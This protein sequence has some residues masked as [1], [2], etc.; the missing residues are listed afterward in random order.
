MRDDDRVKIHGDE[1]FLEAIVGAV[2]DRPFFLD[3]TAVK[4]SEKRAVTDR[5]YNPRS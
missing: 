1:S 4:P 2:C 3:S 5:P